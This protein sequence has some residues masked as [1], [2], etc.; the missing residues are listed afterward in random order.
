MKEALGTLEA[1]DD[2]SGTGPDRLPARILKICAN[3][4][5][6]PVCNLAERIL[7]TG[8]WP[9]IWRDHWVASIFKRHAVFE[10][11]N[12]RGVHLTAQLSKVVERLLLSMM[13]PYISRLNVS[14]LSQFAY[15]KERGARDV[16]ALLVEVDCNP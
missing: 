2:V 6:A 12:Y 14:C 5:S 9:A 16:L 15:A 8:G 13:V 4:L 1:L 3:Q 11:K 7:E 10:A